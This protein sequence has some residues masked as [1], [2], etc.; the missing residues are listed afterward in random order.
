MNYKEKALE[1]RFNAQ[2]ISL[3]TLVLDFKQVLTSGKKKW[4][5]ATAI[6]RFLLKNFEKGK[7]GFTDLIAIG[8][9]I[10]TEPE[11][12]RTFVF[13]FNKA[14]DIVDDKR[15]KEIEETLLLLVAVRRWILIFK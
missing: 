2:I 11:K 1:I 10:P 4:K 12:L 13:R 9:K 8:Q 3:I 15:E 6:G 14:F 7:T 5:M